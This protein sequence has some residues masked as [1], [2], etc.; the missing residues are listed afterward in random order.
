MSG[1]L[2]YSG[3]TAKV[4]TMRGKFLTAQNYYSMAALES[5]PEAAHFLSE[6]PAYRNTFSA[7]D[8][9]E[10]HRSQIEQRLNICLYE[11]FAKLYRFCGVKQRHILDFYFKQIEIDQLKRC[12]RNVFSS[13]P[14]PPGLMRFEPF[15]KKHSRL[16]LE[17]L[18]SASSLEEFLS[19]LNGT[20]YAAVLSKLAETDAP[21]SFALETAL[22][23]FYFRYAWNFLKK[24]LK[25][26]E[27]EAFISCFGSRLDLL[28]L[29]WIY[30]AKKYYRLPADALRPLLIPVH[31]QLKEEQLNALLNAEQM[32][33]FHSELMKTGYG[34]KIPAAQLEERPNP[35]LLCRLVLNHIY[36][37]T[38]K[39]NPYSASA[40]YSYLYFKEEELHMIITIIESI[41]YHA[42]AADIIDYIDKHQT[43]GNLP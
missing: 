17:A 18:S 1:I 33:D 42:D 11:D 30:R 5:V 23:L 38:E 32:D 7:F 21:D 16:P 15:F 19:L 22:D 12:L 35:E 20:E 4:R 8:E 36:H 3:I 26:D 29:Q 41:R 25:K 39:R 37:M 2:T 40:L 34:R 31:Y 27:R 14:S 6:F 28:N 43:R 13:Q 10:L 9:N 24:K